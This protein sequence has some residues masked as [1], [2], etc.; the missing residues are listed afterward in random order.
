MCLRKNNFFCQCVKFF[1]LFL[2]SEPSFNGFLLSP[3]WPSAP[4]PRLPRADPRRPHGSGARPS[5]GPQAFRLSSFRGEGI[6]SH[7]ALENKGGSGSEFS[8]VCTL[9]YRDNPLGPQS[10]GSAFKYSC[11][12]A[13]KS[14]SFTDLHL[15]SL[16]LCSLIL[17]LIITRGISASFSPASVV[18]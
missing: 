16:I 13:P 14:S 5:A 15:C 10:V 1:N 11:G 6:A 9:T 8:F 4:T 17:T 2:F 12:F 18:F 7:S 3:L